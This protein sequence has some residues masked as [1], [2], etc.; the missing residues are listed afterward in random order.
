MK[1]VRI[2]ISLCGVDFAY[3]QGEEVC[4]PCE[5]ADSLINANQAELIEESESTET[6]SLQEL[7]LEGAT[8]E[9]VKSSKT[10]K[11]KQ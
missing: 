7:A 2:L 3:S 10:S 11:K 9:L 5:L 8:E 6:E 1:K 4:L